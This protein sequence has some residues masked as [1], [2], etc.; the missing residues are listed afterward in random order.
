[1]GLYNRKKVILEKPYLIDPYR[2]ISLKEARRLWRLSG[3]PADEVLLEAATSLTTNE[4]ISRKLVRLKKNN[5]PPVF[6]KLRY[7]FTF[8]KAA[9]VAYSVGLLLVGFMMFSVPGRAFAMSVYNAVTKIVQNMLYIRPTSENFP[10]QTQ[11]IEPNPIPQSS[12]EDYEIHPRGLIEAYNH[13]DNTFI[14]L[15]SPS[16]SITNLEIKWSSIS[17]LTFDAIYTSHEGVNIIIRHRWPVDL[18]ELEVNVDISDKN[19]RS[20]D[21]KAGFPIAGILSDDNI[22]VGF[23]LWNNAVLTISIYGNSTALEW[24]IIEKILDELDLYHP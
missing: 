15:N 12:I 21:L 14:A 20:K 18:N 13:L 5:R 9:L 24:Q 11:S 19:Y 2:S 8:K 7:A 3:Y 23:S 16:Y 10:D 22:Y 1:M 4:K 17:G 6:E